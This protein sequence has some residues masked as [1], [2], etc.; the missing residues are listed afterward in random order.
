MNIKNKAIK[1]GHG[2]NKESPTILTGISITGLISTAILAARA[3]PAAGKIIEEADAK[4]NWDE[5]LTLLEKVKLTWKLYLPAGLV[6][7]STITCIIGA[8]S[9]H[10]RRNAALVGLYTFTEGA[11]K[12][13]QQKVIEVIGDKKDGK[14]R[15]EIAQ[16]KL[17]KNPID[18]YN[19]IL[20]GQGQHL[21]YD[22]LSSRYFKSDIETVRKAINDFN[23]ELFKDMYR[24]LNDFYDELDIEG[25]EMGR[26]MGWN[27]EDGTLEVRFSAKI[28]TSGEP[29]VVLNYPV[30]PRFL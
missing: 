9:I 7:L 29:C 3:A 25:T 18:G 4:L 1:L 11:L 27:V 24:T 8:N 30:Q 19:V 16:D 21:F 13:Y 26:N 15:D 14:I 28:A 5:D 17:D 10:L 20:T 22:S 12:E 2:I 6:G 23:V